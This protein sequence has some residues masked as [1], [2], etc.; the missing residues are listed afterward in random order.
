MARKKKENRERKPAAGGPSKELERQLRKLG[1]GLEATRKLEAKR[2]RQLD[3]VHRR[4][5]ALQATIAAL[6]PS[7]GPAATAGPQAYCMREKRTVAMADPVAIVMRN[8]R[9]GLSGTCPSCGAR[10][11][12]TARKAVAPDTGD[13]PPPLEA[14][15]SA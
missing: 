13:G 1:R 5:Q 6:R 2:A 3:K 10:V 7:A 9:N 11:V 15:P 4:A 12:T 14:Q 8:G